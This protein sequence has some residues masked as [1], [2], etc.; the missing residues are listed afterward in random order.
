MNEN[1]CFSYADFHKTYTFLSAN[2]RKN[3]TRPLIG[4][5]DVFPRAEKSAKKIEQVV[6]K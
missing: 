4:R 1:R 5:V 6:S 2:T 3:I